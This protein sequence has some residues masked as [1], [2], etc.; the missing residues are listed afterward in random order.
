MF[1]SNSLNICQFSRHAIFVHTKYY[2]ICPGRTVPQLLLIANTCV[3]TASLSGGKWLCK[4][5]HSHPW[6]TVLSP[7]SSACR[8]DLLHP[9]CQRLRRLWCNLCKLPFKLR[10][11]CP[12]LSV[13][14]VPPPLLVQVNPQPAE[15]LSI[16]L[17]KLCDR[18]SAWTGDQCDKSR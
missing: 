7:V 3:L 5:H 18:L 12:S 4:P 16:F 6:L 8:L 14:R 13:L 1:F 15:Q 10:H 9:C 11:H 2:H 17:L